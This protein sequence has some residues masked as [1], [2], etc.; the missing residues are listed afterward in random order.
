MGII[1]KTW[2]ERQSLVGTHS[3]SISVVVSD[4]EPDGVSIDWALYG[5]VEKGTAQS[6]YLEIGTDLPAANLVL[7][8]FQ[9]LSA[10]QKC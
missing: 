5:V 1:L 9:V 8:G 10:G 6:P 4:M 7:R 2:E 3:F